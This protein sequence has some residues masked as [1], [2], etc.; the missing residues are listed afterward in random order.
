V[1][2]WGEASKFIYCRSSGDSN[3]GRYVMESAAAA[4]TLCQ[5]TGVSSFC[6]MF[7]WLFLKVLGVTHINTNTKKYAKNQIPKF[8]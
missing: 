6:L 5:I 1:L 7:I 4:E 3:S 8:A 2:G